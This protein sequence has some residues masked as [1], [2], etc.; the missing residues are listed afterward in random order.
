MG[1]KYNSLTDT[2][3]NLTA[4]TFLLTI[5]GGAAN[6]PIVFPT[7]ASLDPFIT[8]YA[9]GYLAAGGSRYIQFDGRDVTARCVRAA[10][11]CNVADGLVWMDADGPPNLFF[12][13]SEAV[14]FSGD[15]LLNIDFPTLNTWFEIDKPLPVSPTAAGADLYCLYGRPSSLCQPVTLKTNSI[16]TEWDGGTVQ[17]F[18]GIEIEHTFP[19][20]TG[21]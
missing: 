20:K 21:T 18:V 9:K 3:R 7:S 17:F 8:D 6:S 5:P 19:M 11:F 10:L 2:L 15:R 12:Q 1:N 13:L 16:G 4:P 14:S